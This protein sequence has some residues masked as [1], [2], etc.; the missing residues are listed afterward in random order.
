MGYV[1]RAY[2]AQLER[3]VAVKVLQAM[4]PEPDTTARFRHEAQAIAQ[5]RHPNILNVYDFGEYEGSPYMIVEYVPGGN[6]ADRLTQGHL[7]HSRALHYLRG[8]SA[9]LDYAH[10][11]GVVHRDIKPANVLLEKDD[12]PVLADFGLAK[13]LQGSSVTSLTGESTWRPGYRA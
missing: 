13:L 10:R 3:T 11:H 6:L 12:T 7:D 1:F 5:M 2:H 8:I 9:G 4:A